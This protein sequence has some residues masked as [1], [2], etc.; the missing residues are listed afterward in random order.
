MKR[1]LFKK[2]AVWR[3]LL[4]SV[5]GYT[6]VE[7]LLAF[8]IFIAVAVPLIGGIFKNN[9][10]LRSQ[11]MLVAAWLLEQEAMNVR[12]YPDKAAAAKKR[13]AAGK[14]WVIQIEKS[15]SPLIHYHLSAIRKSRKTGELYVDVFK[16]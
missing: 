1:Y 7:V 8:F 14:E 16:K 3:N 4:R 6:L 15:G 12:L 11:D 10:S 5:S 2:T 13:T 9:A